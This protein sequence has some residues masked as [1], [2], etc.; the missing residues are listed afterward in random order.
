VTDGSR[1]RGIKKSSYSPFPVSAV[2]GSRPLPPPP[3]YDKPKSVLPHT[4]ENSTSGTSKSAPDIDKMAALKAY[5][6]AM[7][8][9]FKCGEKWVHNHKCSNTVQLHVVQELW[10]L[11]QLH[12]DESVDPVN[13]ESCMILSSEASTGQNT[14]KT[15]KLTGTVQ[16]HQV[17]ILVDSG[18]T[19]TFISQSLAS[20]LHG[21]TSV[22]TP[23]AVQV[24]NGEQLLCQ[25]EFLNMHWSVHSCAFSSTLKV[26]P[27]QHYDMILGM[28][29]L[30][31]FSPMQIH[32]SDK[33][34]LL[35]YK[36]SLVRL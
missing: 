16:G 23:I 21:V 7:G 24:A 14:P 31:R 22:S 6:R 29:W 5:H 27:L 2:K 1:S 20:K 17:T 10:E 13:S 35:P 36:G 28:E 8:L 33:W 12:T 9:C 15:L 25:T 18:S 19:H 3:Q 11:F 30:E 34:T 32:W 4:S 26:L